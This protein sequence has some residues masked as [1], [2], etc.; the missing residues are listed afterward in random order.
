MKCTYNFDTVIFCK[1]YKNYN[2]RLRII[3]IDQIILLLLPIFPYF[4]QPGSIKPL[5][6]RKPILRFS[7]PP[8]ETSKLKVTKRSLSLSLR[9][10]P[11]PLNT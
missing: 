6:N 11:S 3:L 8:P 7:H 10:S 4:S 9:L 1:R 2:K 5:T